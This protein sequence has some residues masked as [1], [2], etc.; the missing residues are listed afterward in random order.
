[1]IAGPTAA[2]AMRAVVIA[3]SGMNN[4]AVARSVRSALA[5]IRGVQDVEVRPQSAEAHVRFDPELVDD[6]QLCRA[7]Q[8]VGC[9]GELRT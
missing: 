9:R 8:A 4:A 5:L 2:K 7:V 3:I 6:W 1:M